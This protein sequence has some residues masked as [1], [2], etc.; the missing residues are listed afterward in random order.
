MKWCI[1]F[2][3]ES[4]LIMRPSLR[5]ACG[6]NGNAA[7]FLAYLTYCAST[8]EGNKDGQ[9]ITIYR[10]QGTIIKGMD[11]ELS[12]RTLRDDAEPCL[13]ELGYLTT[14]EYKG[15]KNYTAYTI[16][17]ELIQQ[18]ISSPEKVPSYKTLKYWI[19]L[20]TKKATRKKLR[21][22]NLP[23][24]SEK[25]PNR[26]GKNS[27]P[28]GKNS[29]PENSHEAASEV[30]VNGHIAESRFNLKNSEIYNQEKERREEP[31]T[32]SLA[33]DSFFH[34]SD[35]E[36]NLTPE[37]KS[38]GDVTLPPASVEGVPIPPSNLAN[39][40]Q[41]ENGVKNSAQ[42][43]M[44][45]P[46]SDASVL[47]TPPQSVIPNATFPIDIITDTAALEVQ[48]STTMPMD[49]YT[50]TGQC[51]NSEDGITQEVIIG[52]ARKYKVYVPEGKADSEERIANAM[53]ILLPL[54]KCE[55]HIIDLKAI[56]KRHWTKGVIS[57]GNLANV[58]VTMEFE[59]SQNVPPPVVTIEPLTEATRDAL[60]R[61]IRA[62][63]P[64]LYMMPY[65]QDN[66]L[67]LII[68][69]GPSNS[70]FQYIRDRIDWDIT[71]SDSWIMQRAIAYGKLAL[72]QEAVAV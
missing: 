65:E 40:P 43:S 21:S 7:K 13:K 4:V 60:G 47:N 10:T 44:E 24:A 31:P 50:Q 34:S 64:M 72:E 27:E 68:W 57:L 54:V 1:T 26:S 46:D 20:S 48:N 66:R 8:E 2:P 37:L 45:P 29:E 63:Y 15:S 17:P 11:D 30:S 49:G 55:Q 62:E 41:G 28:L 19:E 33:T 52:W 35:N 12:D 6:G 22:E 18:G 53:K 14:I 71:R 42:S 25:T 61:E 59:E 3:K 36:I 5:K 9:G 69:H 70:E 32:S 67:Y 56:C 51:I 23:D 58:A 38:S 16:Y 39:A